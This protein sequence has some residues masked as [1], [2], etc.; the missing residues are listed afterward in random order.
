MF[1]FDS[2]SL[3]LCLMIARQAFLLTGFVV[4]LQHRIVPPSPVF[5]ERIP[6]SGRKII[7]APAYH[8]RSYRRN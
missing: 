8:A 1:P 5:S 6:F 4:P 2:V 3:H 7:S